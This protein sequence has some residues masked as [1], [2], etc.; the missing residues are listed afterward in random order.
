[1]MN[2]ISIVT[3]FEFVRYKAGNLIIISAACF[4]IPMAMS[5]IGSKTSDYLHE[6]KKKK[7]VLVHSLFLIKYS[8]DN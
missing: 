1:M 8:F 4:S 3:W 2:V 5:N 7:I 6:F